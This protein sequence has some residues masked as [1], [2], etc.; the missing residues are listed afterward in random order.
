MESQPPAH[1]RILIADN[2]TSLTLLLQLLFEE[3]GYLVTIA[4]TL[5]EAC[6]Q[7]AAGEFDIVLADS[8]SRQQSQVLATTAP[9][10]EAAGA[11]PVVLFTAYRVAR[12]EALRAGFDEVLPKPIDLDVLVARV[13]RLLSELTPHSPPPTGAK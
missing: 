7:L 9:I 10:R 12:A 13:Q 5:E 8:F 1:P 6:A 2:N 3:A 11:I 4:G